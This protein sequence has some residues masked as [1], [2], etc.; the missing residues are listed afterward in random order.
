MPFGPASVGPVRRAL[1]ALAVGGFAIGTSEFLMLGLL[2]QVADDLSVSIPQ[3]GQLISVY[4]LGVVV[5]AP[6]LTAVTVRMDRRRVLIGLMS[7]YAVANLVTATSPNFPFA[8]VARFATGLPHGAFFGVGSVVA[9]GL[10]HRSKSTTA[11]SVM[12]AGLTVANI[13]GVPVSTLLGQSTSWRLVYALVG[14]IAA[15]AAISVALFVPTVGERSPAGALAAELRTFANPKVWLVL[16][17]ATLGGGGLFATFTYITPMMTKQAGYADSS[18]TW[19]L[20]LFGLGMTAGNLVG[21]PLA[22]RF[23]LRTLS[24]TL[25]TEI[26]LALV[27]AMSTH[28][29]FASAVLIFLLP[30]TALAALPALQSRV[31]ALAGGA[32]NLA[33]ASIQGAFN[34]ANSLGAY[35]GGVAIDA[36]YGYASPNVV[37]AGLVTL[38]LLL[39]FWLAR[40]DRAGRAN[41]HVAAEPL[42]ASAA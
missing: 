41:R 29:E 3:A 16:G 18:M 19:L 25:S 2:P 38:G 33:A 34:V 28:N 1:L 36:G 20:V 35:L 10:V 30:A 32:P 7:W 14:G 23:P 24:I 27:F 9:G 31:I 21:A 13:V 42:T 12:F 5:G 11:M 26:V 4:A 40:T 6:L 15:L 17:I 22:D 37:A 8:L 39:T